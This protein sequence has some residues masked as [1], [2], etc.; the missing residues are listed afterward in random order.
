M[1]A[2]IESE[3][4]EWLMQVEEKQREVDRLKTLLRDMNFES[5]I[6]PESIKLSQTPTQQAF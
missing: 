6:V 1:V 5:S 3:R 2:A 4:Q